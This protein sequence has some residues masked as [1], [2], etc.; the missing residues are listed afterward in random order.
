[1]L[2]QCPQIRQIRLRMYSNGVSCPSFCL[3]LQALLSSLHYFRVFLL[4]SLRFTM[5]LCFSSPRS[6]TSIAKPATAL[7]PFFKE[8]YPFRGN[9]KAPGRATSPGYKLRLI[10]GASPPPLVPTPLTRS[11]M[12]NALFAIPLCLAV[13]VA[14]S[15]EKPLEARA[16]TEISL[17][18]SVFET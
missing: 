1:M 18:L 16:G 9:S 6:L 7:C 3:S 14:A 12:R 17:F 2:L 10:N 5:L 8:A 15:E 4:P 11:I 13:A